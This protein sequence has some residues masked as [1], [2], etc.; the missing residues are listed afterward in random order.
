MPTYTYRPKT[1]QCCDACRDTLEI[2]HGMSEPNKTECPHCGA[3]IV[4]TISV[5]QISMSRYGEITDAKINRS[6]MTK[7]KNIGDGKYEK[8]AGPAD[9]PKIVDRSKLPQN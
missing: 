1:D 9:A 7:Y 8:V 2:F 5:P 3:P 6:G 4:K